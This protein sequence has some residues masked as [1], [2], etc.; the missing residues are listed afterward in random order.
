MV[1]SSVHAPL[2]LVEI[3]AIMCFVRVYYAQ[4]TQTAY[5]LAV[6]SYVTFMTAF[7]N[8][9][10]AAVHALTDETTTRVDASAPATLAKNVKRK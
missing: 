10:A 8:R 7:H 1:M 2:T 5:K 6:T 3:I 4:S 9:I